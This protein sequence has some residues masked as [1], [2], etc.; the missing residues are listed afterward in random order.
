MTTIVGIQ[1][2]SFAL[3][4]ADSRSAEVD[5]EGYATQVVT[6][7]DGS[8]KIVINGRYIIG[9][10]G[11]VRAI[12]ILHH[13]FQP[14]AAPPNLKG[15]KLDQFITIKFIPALR[16]CFD[17]HGYSMAEHHDRKQHI[18]E[19]D[20]SVI[21]AVNNCIYTIEGDYSWHSDVS[22]VYA[23]GTGAQYA[24]GALH[25]LLGHG[26]PSI[27]SARKHALKSLAAAARFDPYTG[28]PYQTFVQ[29]GRKNLETKTN[30]K[31][32]SAKTRGNK[33]K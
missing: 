15:R 2:D 25:A 24:M 10:A 14:P 11:D 17:Q 8:G 28:S 18:A 3:L 31:S 26:R 9:A 21:V 27:Q 1:G 33:S 22:G 7:R 32:R 19:M 29:D 30:K 4:C 23:I 16:E 6:M 20:S 5:D 12:N 13:A